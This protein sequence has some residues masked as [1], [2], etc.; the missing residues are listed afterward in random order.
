MAAS[1]LTAQEWAKRHAAPRKRRARKGSYWAVRVVL[2]GLQATRRDSGTEREA[3]KVPAAF[4]E[5][6][7]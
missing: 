1:W 5:L 6:L 4:L 7:P 3:R 2:H